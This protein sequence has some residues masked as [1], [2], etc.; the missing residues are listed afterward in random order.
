MPLTDSFEETI[1]GTLV[2]DPY[3]WLEDRNSPETNDWIRSQQRLCDKYFDSC[4]GLNAIERRVRDYLDVEVV[5]QPAC[6]RSR[7]FYRKRSTGQ[8]QGTICMREISG[9]SERILVNPFQDGR[10]TSVG[11][12][13][14]SPDGSLAR[15]QAAST[16]GQLRRSELS[17][18]TTFQSTR[19]SCRPSFA[20]GLPVSGRR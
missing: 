13:R 2:R 1:H 16:H 5:D 11:I 18:I 12:H 6:V 9:D 19:R 20:E 14:I 4:P 7:Y 3:R 10:F 8:D 17:I 15:Y